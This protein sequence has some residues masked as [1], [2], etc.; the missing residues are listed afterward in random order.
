MISAAANVYDVLPKSQAVQLMLE[1][2][3]WADVWGFE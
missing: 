3:S 2:I 1:K